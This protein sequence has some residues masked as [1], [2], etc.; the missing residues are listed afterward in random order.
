M[1]I[2]REFSL[3]KTLTH[4]NV[5]RVARTNFEVTAYTVVPE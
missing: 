4:G 5:G 3:V 1:V 2:V